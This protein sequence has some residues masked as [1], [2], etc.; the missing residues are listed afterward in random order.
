MEVMSGERGAH[1]REVHPYRS[2][3]VLVL[4]KC[5]TP[6][7][8]I[9][10]SFILLTPLRTKEFLSCSLYNDTELITTSTFVIITIDGVVIGLFEHFITTTVNG[11]DERV[12]IPRFCEVIPPTCWQPLSC[13]LIDVKV[14]TR[15][16]VEQDNNI[17][18][19]CSRNYDKHEQNTSE[20]VDKVLRYE[21]KLDTLKS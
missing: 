7:L 21:N 1:G 15:A 4:K 13:G 10:A 12:V 16:S 6:T 5:T 17:R 3:H 14:V 9:Q 2:I 8:W 19:K 18:N 11:G 20:I